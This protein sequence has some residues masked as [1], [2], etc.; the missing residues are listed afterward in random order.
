M[1]L[2]EVIRTRRKGRFTVEELS[3]RAGVSSGLISQIERGKGNPSFKTMQ[4]LAA[5]LDLPIGALFQDD[6]ATA[7][8]SPADSDGADSISLH[9]EQQMVVRRDARKKLLFPKESMVWELLTPDLNR[10]LEMLRAVV[11]ADYDTRE[12]PFVHQGEEC[13]HIVR[14]KLEVHIGEQ[15]FALEAG[16]TITYDAAVPHWWRNRGGTEAE[17]ISACTPP[18]F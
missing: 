10:T 2:G 16:D 1:R 4:R 3:D 11:P 8:G 17:V 6:A 7:A 13:V 9:H 5:A 15:V 18:S 14:G 12:V